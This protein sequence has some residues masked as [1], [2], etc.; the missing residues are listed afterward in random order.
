MSVVMPYYENHLTLGL[1]L[2]SLTP[3]RP[4]E[5]I[6]VDD[7]SPHPARGVLASWNGGARAVTLIEQPNCGQSAA[8]NAG[9]QAARGELVLLTC[10]D[11]EAHPDLEGEEMSQASVDLLELVR[12][13]EIAPRFIG[14]G[15]DTGD[16][17]RT[18][19]R[20][21]AASDWSRE[22]GRAGER[23]AETGEEKLR[24]GATVS[25][26]QAFLR[27]SLCHHIAQFL[28]FDD[29]EE[30]RRHQERKV[31]L[32]NQARP[33]LR[34][35]VERLEVP[36]EGITLPAYFRR[37]EGERGRSPCV[38]F[39]EG[40][41]S[42]KEESV[43]IGNEFLARGM[44]AFAF[45]G[46]GRG[47]TWYRMKMRPD[48]EKATQAVLDF[49][50]KRPDVDASRIGVLG[51]S[52]GGHL[53]PR[54]AAADPRI[55]A[56]VSMGGYFDTSFYRWEEPLRRIRFQFICGTKTLEETQRV[57]REFTLAGRRIACPVLVVDGTE[58]RGVPREQARRILEACAGE[59]SL[60]VIE[61]GNHVCH[62][63]S[64]EVWA[65]VTDWMKGHLGG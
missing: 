15:L 18:L 22:W 41:D 46:P 50:T 32:F 54:S 58:D 21:A 55:K 10:A 24:R 33:H 61:G 48:Y 51:R 42:T 44:A 20:I 17:E 37:P 29:L 13:G 38:V 31:A 25:A 35:P 9:V 45:D 27:A 8:T 2:S 63:F 52:F 11:I 65:L 12:A 23:H 64:R 14:Q 40:T 59:R 7:G 49:L 5:I 34:P 16:I 30:K 26:G 4:F 43:A 53:A 1:C 56:C 39:I 6:V 28:S 19:P 3:Q 62:N 47:E 57:A 36:F 60:V